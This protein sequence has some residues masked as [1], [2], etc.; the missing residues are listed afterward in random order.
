MYIFLPS[1][2]ECVV[3]LILQRTS[4]KCTQVMMVSGGQSNII[5][6]LLFHPVC[7]ISFGL[8]LCCRIKLLL[9]TEETSYFP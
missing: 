4:L 2:T 9:G 5:I 6:C 3:F 8:C 1:C 7:T